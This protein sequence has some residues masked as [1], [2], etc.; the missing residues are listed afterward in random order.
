M[1]DESRPSGRQTS[2]PRQIGGN[3]STRRREARLRRIYLNLPPDGRDW[4][5]CIRLGYVRDRR[6][7]DR[8]ERR[9]A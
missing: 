8:V 4:A 7:W 1:N 9:S 2:D 6:R 3:D 5:E